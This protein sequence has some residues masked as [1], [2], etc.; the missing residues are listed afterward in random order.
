MHR[1]QN[2]FLQKKNKL[3][4]SSRLLDFKIDEVRNL[5]VYFF[6]NYHIRMI[7]IFMWDNIERD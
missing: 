5:F 3:I 7:R 1:N 6:F 2:A 4:S